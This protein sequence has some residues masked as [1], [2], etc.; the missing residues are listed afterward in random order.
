MKEYIREYP[1]FSLCGLNCGLCPRHNTSS[2]S[3]CPGCGGQGFRLKHP[4]CAV[5]NCN[6][7]HDNVEFCSQ[8]SCYPCDKYSI[9]SSTDSFITYKNV[10]TDFKK[11]EKN[12]LDNYKADLNEKM[13]TLAY[14]LEHYNDGRR[15][16]YY[17]NAVNLLSIE[18][19][20]EIKE[21]ISSKVSRL[22]IIFFIEEKALKS[23]IELVL[24]K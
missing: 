6:K 20:R 7:R 12:G 22:D 19:V 8:C 3:Q 11:L 15:K 21:Y 18:D 14:L 10:I 2:M 17:C 23:N 24:R 16:N 5:I 13:D 1:F 9:T 4:S